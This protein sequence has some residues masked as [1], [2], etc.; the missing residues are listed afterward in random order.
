MVFCRL[1]SL[2]AECWP[3]GASGSGC[4][5]GVAVDIASLHI[6]W[7]T[8]DRVVCHVS[9]LSAVLNFC[10]GRAAAVASAGVAGCLSLQSMHG[11]LVSETS[12]CCIGVLELKSVV[13][14]LDSGVCMTERLSP[15]PAMRSLFLF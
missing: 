6:D 10:S 1:V 13:G 12:A 5:C 15:K 8:E 9:Q 3:F 7:W 11:M 14:V 2:W 4:C